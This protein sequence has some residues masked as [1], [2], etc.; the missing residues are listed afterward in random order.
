MD[1]FVYIG[2]EPEDEIFFPDDDDDDDDPDDGGLCECSICG[3]MIPWDGYDRKN[4]NMWVCEEC[5]EHFCTKCFWDRHG[6]AEFETA[7]KL[8][9]MMCPD[10][11]VVCYLE[12]NEEDD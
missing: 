3:T 5:G 6:E 11:Y 8:S 9:A 2:D 1:D 4:G 10:C 7:C 12:H